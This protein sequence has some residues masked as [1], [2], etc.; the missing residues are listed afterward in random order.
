MRKSSFLRDSI[1][2][3]GLI[4]AVGFCQLTAL[5]LDSQAELTN[6]ENRLFHHDFNGQDIKSRVA[7]LEKNVFGDEL[8]GTMDERINRLVDSAKLTTTSQDA[9]TQVSEATEPK[10]PAVNDED[11]AIQRAQ[12]AVKAAGE[13]ETGK[14]LAE[15][16]KQ[17]R[18][19]KLL[20]SRE[21]FEQVIHVDPNNCDAN[22][23]LG[24]IDE[25]SGNL[26]E[27]LSSYKKALAARPDKVEYRDAVA[28]LQEKMKQY[29]G[30]DSRRVQIRSL[31]SAAMRAYMKGEYQTALNLYL[32]LDQKSPNQAIVKSNLATVYI[33]LKEPQK[34]VE[35]YKQAVQLNPYDDRFKQG[36]SHAEDLVA[37]APKQDPDAGLQD[38]LEQFEKPV[39]DSSFQNLGLRVG[40][41]TR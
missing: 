11:C 13:E 36:L 18:D 22:F 33:A 8:E 20:A 32:A 21:L 5:A 10:E 37:Q 38:K 2:F 26:A 40:N 19:G 17:F 41:A 35:Y 3:A 27:A 39:S 30:L 28:A 31:S 15:A 7:R 1:K 9:P 12:I 29:G 16:V 34:A 25:G 24:I 14:L 4:I 6:L 23:S